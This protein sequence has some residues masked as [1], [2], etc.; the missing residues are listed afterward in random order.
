MLIDGPKLIPESSTSAGAK[1]KKMRAM[2]CQVS[3]PVLS[4]GLIMNP[5]MRGDTELPGF[6]VNSIGSK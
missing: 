2:C 4:L 5:D 6:I 1:V 3:Y